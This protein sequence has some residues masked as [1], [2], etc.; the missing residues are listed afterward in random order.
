ME[1]SQVAV[2]AAVSALT[3]VGVAVVTHLLTRAQDRRKYQREVAEKLAEHERD[4]AAKVAALN[5]VRPDVTQIYAMQFAVGC[6]MV[7]IQSE[8]EREPVFLPLGSRIT[9]GRSEENHIRI[10]DPYISLTH[11]SFSSIHDKVY[12]ERLDPSDP[13]E[14]NGK[15]VD[16]KRILATGDVITVPKASMEIKFVRVVSDSPFEA[17]S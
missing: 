1:L 11:A 5:S 4:V 16:L 9:L 10:N 15:I 2:N 13:L 8:G 17:G 6:F 12:V 14:V 7:E 3:A